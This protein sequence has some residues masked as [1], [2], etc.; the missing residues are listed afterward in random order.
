MDPLTTRPIQTGWEIAMEPY[1]SG[2]LRCIDDQDVQFGNGSVWT[3]T[4]TRSDGPEPLLPL[5]IWCHAILHINDCVEPGEYSTKLTI[6]PRC[7]LCLFGVI[8]VEERNEE[9]NQ[10]H[11]RKWNKALWLTHLPLIYPMICSSESVDLEGRR[12][13]FNIPPYLL[14]H[15]QGILEQA[16]LAWGT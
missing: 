5:H 14:Q 7:W 9:R 11:W 16:V 1:P 12:P 3:R 10:H 15:C 8:M 4:R 2:Q 6:Q 13:I